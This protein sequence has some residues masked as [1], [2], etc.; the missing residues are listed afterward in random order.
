M[1]AMKIYDVFDNGDWIG[2]YTADAITKIYEIPRRRIIENASTGAA[3]QNRYT[4]KS[5]MNIGTGLGTWAQQWDAA[6]LKLLEA[7]R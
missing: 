1:P 4:F 6:R 7:G 2:S 5:V 3:A